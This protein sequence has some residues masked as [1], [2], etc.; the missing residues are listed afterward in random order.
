MNPRVSVAMRRA[1]EQEILGVPWT[2]FADLVERI[3]AGVISADDDKARYIIGTQDPHGNHVFYGP[4]ATA[5]AAN[6]AVDLG[7]CAHIEGTSALAFP[8]VPAPK[9]PKKPSA[10]RG[11][12]DA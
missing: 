3:C 9:K 1:V 12:T 11:K 6:K 5:D 4:Y 10:R 8:L 7:L 2:T